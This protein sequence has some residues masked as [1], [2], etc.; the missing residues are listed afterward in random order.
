MQAYHYTAIDKKGHIRHGHVEAATEAKAHLHCQRRGWVIIKLDTGALPEKTK[1][2]TKPL[3]IKC[4]ALFARQLGSLLDAGLPLLAALQTI[5]KSTPFK[6]PLYAHLNQLLHLLNKGESLKE[7]MS[8]SKKAWGA[9]FFSTLCAGEKAGALPT[10]LNGLTHWAEGVAHL[11]NKVI[12]ALIYPT[13][14]L[15][16]AAVMVMGLLL[17]IVPQFEGLFK[18]L[19]GANT[20]LPPLT[21]CVLGV[22]HGLRTHPFIIT[23]IGFI[24]LAGLYHSMQKP[25]VQKIKHL[26]LYHLPLIKTPAQFTLRARLFKTLGLLLSSGLSL[27]EALDLT[28]QMLGSR[29]TPL[30]SSL[31]T[32]LTGLRQGGTLS[33]LLAKDPLFPQTNVSLIEAGETAGTLPS[34]LQHLGEMEAQAAATAISRLLAGMEPALVVMLSLII[35]GLIIALFLPVMELMGALTV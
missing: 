32:V 4:L 3:P 23:S 16:F 24:A 33:Q 17:G 35:G 12:T 1:H 34:I 19:L 31:S 25:W 8:V 6:S 7:A 22:S 21:Q 29:T 2:K 13:V 26:A 18:T 10:V 28:S 30:G 11:Q 20:V 5:L 27:H 9:V 14:V 15:S